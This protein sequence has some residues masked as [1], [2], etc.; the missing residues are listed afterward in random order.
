M[1]NCYLPIANRSKTGS[2]RCLTTER[3][4]TNITFIGGNDGCPQ[5]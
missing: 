5:S 3:A 4:L 1:A 2:A